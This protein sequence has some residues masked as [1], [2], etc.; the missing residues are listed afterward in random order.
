[1]AKSQQLTDRE[2]QTED[3]LPWLTLEADLSLTIFQDT[4]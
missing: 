4:F 1:M 2:F 3:R